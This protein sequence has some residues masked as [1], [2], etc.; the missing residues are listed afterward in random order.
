MPNACSPMYKNTNTA[1]IKPD[2]KPIGTPIEISNN[3]PTISIIES[4][5]ISIL[6]QFF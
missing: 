1:P 4:D 5:P 3:N 2:A 6:F